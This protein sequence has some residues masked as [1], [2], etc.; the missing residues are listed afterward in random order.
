MR[1]ILRTDIEKLGKL[2]E[3]V[4]VKPGYARNYLL[5]KKLA[6]LATPSNLKIFEHEKKKLEEKLN[7]ERFKAKELAEKLEKERIEIQV[8]VGEGDKLYGSVTSSNIVDE[9]AKRGFEIDRK[10]VEL[11][12]PIR[13]LG[14]YQI[15]VK[16]Y[17]GVVATLNVSVVRYQ[18]EGDEQASQ[19]E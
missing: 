19:G 8:R 5:P 14:E 16:L 11:D 15:P 1:V 7:A 3:V 6:M 10:K 2:G 18:E 13:S 9:L 4:D 17:P 12:K